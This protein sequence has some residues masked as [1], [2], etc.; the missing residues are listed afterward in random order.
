MDTTTKKGMGLLEM[1][2]LMLALVLAS[3]MVGTWIDYAGAQTSRVDAAPALKVY[4]TKV[5]ALVKGIGYWNGL[6]GREVFHLEEGPAPADPTPFDVIVTYDTIADEGFAGVTGG[7]PG[8]MASRITI[9]VGFEADYATYVHELGHTLGFD[10]YNTGMGYGI[11]DQ[12]YHGVM[13]YKALDAGK[14]VKS[15]DQML[16]RGAW[17]FDTTSVGEALTI[18]KE[19]N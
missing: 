17:L 15:D 7:D 2:A 9:D 5:P 13:S 3:L 11:D 12:G 6:T 16:L 8:H 1:V 19:G 14:T 18:T 4:G 10:D